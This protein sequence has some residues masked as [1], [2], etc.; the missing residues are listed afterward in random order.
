LNPAHPD[1]AKVTII[2]V[3]NAPFDPRLLPSP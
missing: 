2:D 3:V 1:A